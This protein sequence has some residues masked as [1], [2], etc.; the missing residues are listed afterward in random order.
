MAVALRRIY[1][2]D[3]SSLVYCQRSFGDRSTKV[4]FYGSIWSLLDRLADDGRLL[5]PHLVYVEITRNKDHVGQW[6][7]DHQGVFRPKGEQAGRVVQV[8]KEPGQRLVDPAAPRG[9]E[10]SDPWVIA[11]AEGISATPPTLW[12]ERQLGV[13]V[14]EETKV[15]GIREICQRRGVEHVDFTEMLTSEGLS[16]GPPAP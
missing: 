3:T 15:G 1:C 16:F 9:A 14:S 12:D 5:A 7:I 2:I 10:E 13:V 6:A 11:L 8:L 4:T